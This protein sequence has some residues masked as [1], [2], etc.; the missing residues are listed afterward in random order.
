MQPHSQHG[1][2]LWA[3]RTL[4]EKPRGF[5]IEAGAYDGVTHSN[6]LMLERLGW[7]GI[8]VEPSA[9]RF[10]S[11]CEN[12]DCVCVHALIAGKQ[13]TEAMFLDSGDGLSGVADQ[14]LYGTA[15]ESVEMKTRRIVEILRKC[16][17]PRAIDYFSLDVE[18]LEIEILSDFPFEE[19]QVAVWTIEHAAL[20]LPERLPI[21]DQ[22]CEMLTER[23]YR[24][25][26]DVCNDGLFCLPPFYESAIES[27]AALAPA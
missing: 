20:N 5:F 18:G 21:K 17:A 8:C 23:G 16:R 27:L 1:Q 6:T 3:F 11:L 24:Y 7:Q 25:V 10:A 14:R 19:Y 22:M 12:R 4:N 9:R 2:D 13:R 26:G 15:A